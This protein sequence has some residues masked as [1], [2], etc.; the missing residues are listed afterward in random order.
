[1]PTIEQAFHLAI[2]HHRAGRVADAENLY[3]QILQYDARHA[4]SLNLLGVIA[5]QR[6]QLDAGIEL[7]GQAIAID[8]GQA[9]FHSNL[10]EAYRRRGEFD[11]ARQCFETALRLDASTSETHNNLGLILQAQGDLP[12][13]RQCFK[14]AIGLRADNAD[15]HY[16][17]ARL[18]LLEGDFSAGWREH[19]WRRLIFG[20]P[21]QRLTGRVWGGRPLHDQTLLVYGEQ[22]LGDNLQFIRYLPLVE[23]RAARLSVQVPGALLSLLTGSGFR[24]LLPLEGPPPPHDVH[25]SFADL[26]HLFETTVETIPAA[27]P[28]LFPDEQLLKAWRSE[29]GQHKGF[30]VGIAWQGNPDFQLDRLRSI[31]LQ[32]FEPLAQVPGV[33]LLSLQKHNGAGQIDAL[34]PRFEVLRFDDHLDVAHG[35]FMDTAALMKC[36]DLVITSDTSIA[37]LAGALAVPTWVVLPQA[38]DWRWLLHR[39]DSP[40]Y[41]TMRLFRQTRMGQWSDVIQIVAAELAQRV[42]SMTSPQGAHQD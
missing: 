22:G 16:N 3:R 32:D 33:R 4:G 2:E 7:I 34:S 20:H 11:E 41:P 18:L 36:L 30:R 8:A 6:G 17:L 1:M 31:P 28:Y 25:C 24:H 29:I 26:P 23:A 19:A 40:W 9:G 39:Q 5:N 27:V 15:A 13:A 35:T 21:S 37:H 10:G 38:P 12:S 14:R 42:S